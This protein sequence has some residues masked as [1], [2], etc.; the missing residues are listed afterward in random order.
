[1]KLDPTHC[2]S[3]TEIYE[4]AENIVEVVRSSGP[5]VAVIGTT[6]QDN[7]VAAV[8]HSR[9][10]RLLLNE[11]FAGQT[12]RTWRALRNSSIWVW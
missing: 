10:L 1:M 7:I 2:P 6:Q 12:T 3:L 9:N 11:C 5:L 8:R 4:I